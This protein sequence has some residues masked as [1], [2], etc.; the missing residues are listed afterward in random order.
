MVL[1]HH[2]TALLEI[3]GQISVVYNAASTGGIMYYDIDNDGDGVVDSLDEFPTD[4]SQQYDS[5]GDGYGDNKDGLN[6]DQ[7]PNNSEQYADSDND[8]YGDNE[9]GEQGDLFPIMVNSG[10]TL[11]AMA[12]ETILKE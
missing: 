1:Q 11:T 2:F 5:D 4:P 12:M 6:G 3:T 9:F 8:G 10:R 7:F